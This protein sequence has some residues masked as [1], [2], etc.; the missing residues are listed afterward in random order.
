MDE[1]ASNQRGSGEGPERVARPDVVVGG[2]YRIETLLGK[3]GMGEVW[4]GRHLITQRPV[5]IKL[6]RR[7]LS[8][9]PDMR[10]R[11]LRESRAAAAINH[12]NVVEVLDAFELEDGT[13]AIVMPLLEGRTLAALIDDDAPLPVDA[14]L[15]ILLPVVEAVAATHARGIV[16]RDLKPENVF[17]ARE[18]GTTVVKVLD[19][20]VAKLATDELDDGTSTAE[21]TLLGTP[22]YMAPEQ[23][24]CEAEQDHRVDIW[25]IGAIGYQL[26]SGCRPV[27]GENAAQVIKS[28]L[29]Q[30]VTPLQVLV[31]DL[32]DVLNHTIMQMLRR[33]RSERPSLVEVLGRLRP[34]VTGSGMEGKALSA[35]YSL[36]TPEQSLSLSE[37]PSIGT[38]AVY[39]TVQPPSNAGST[40][41]SPL[42][43]K[44]S[45]G[46]QRLTVVG[47]AVAAVVAA[48]SVIGARRQTSTSS[49]LSR[50]IE[51]A[52]VQTPSAT[53]APL[54]ASTGGPIAPASA[55]ASASAS[56]LASVAAAASVR[57][58]VVYPRQ[59][60]RQVRATPEAQTRASLDD[61]RPRPIDRTNPFLSK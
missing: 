7:I 35:A 12:P 60:G 53:V 1:T 22:A 56:A 29:T 33:S 13:P 28:L 43:S 55:S 58:P 50:T 51:P 41:R 44:S 47:A 37:R 25:A 17:L 57:A 32:P 2:R 59:Q 49:A 19:F 9:R 46:W 40:L 26:L 15:A 18:A 21:G 14:T 54:A 30:A 8:C 48:S 39:S 10:R 6:L 5:A 20:G 11:F 24:L 34:L 52:S 23:A 42:T 4:Q 3:G 36:A 38:L 31:P 27:E 61:K 45:K 16:H